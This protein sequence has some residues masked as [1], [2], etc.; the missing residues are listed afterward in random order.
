MYWLNTINEIQ[1]KSYVKIRS[2]DIPKFP[3]DRKV[4]SRQDKNHTN[5]IKYNRGEIIQMEFIKRMCYNYFT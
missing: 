4:R 2:A 1:I 5:I 3:K